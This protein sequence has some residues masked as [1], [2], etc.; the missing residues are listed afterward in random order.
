MSYF[1]HQLEFTNAWE[2]LEFLKGDDAETRLLT[3]LTEYHTTDDVQERRRYLAQIRQLAAESGPREVACRFHCVELAL[4]LK[5]PVF[6][7]ACI[8]GQFEADHPFQAC[9]ALAWIAL[10]SGD[11]AAALNHAQKA[12]VQLRPE[13]HPQE[14]QILART[15]TDVGHHA[16]ALDIFDQLAIPG[17]LNDD[18]KSLIN[19]AKQLE[20]HDLLLRICRE[21]RETG[22][23]DDRL[24]RLEIRLLD[25]YAPEQGFAI[26]RDYIRLSPSPAFFVAYRNLLAIRIGQGGRCINRIVEF[27]FCLFL[28]ELRSI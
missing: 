7:T 24:R 18:M 10:A 19:C 26:A 16:E 3:V 6:A 2:L 28:F 21:L 15:L 27:E 4:K 8:T 22:Q 20:R 14:R 11:R 1:L 23:E 9:T 17:L 13:S 12:L 25:R 5:D